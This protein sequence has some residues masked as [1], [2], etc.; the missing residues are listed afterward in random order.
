MI[1]FASTGLGS[2]TA[3]SVET[4]ENVSLINDDG[5]R[6][7]DTQPIPRATDPNPHL[8]LVICDTGAIP[9]RRRN[10]KKNTQSI[11]LFRMLFSPQSPETTRKLPEDPPIPR[12]DVVE[13]P[14]V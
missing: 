4:T 5:V 6:M 7:D 10:G 13:W 1:F 2:K 8:L 9:T 3:N 12:S 14:D 11:H